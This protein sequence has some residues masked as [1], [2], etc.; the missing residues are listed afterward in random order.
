MPSSV[1]PKQI[2]PMRDCL[3]L[4]RFEQRGAQVG[5]Q[6]DGAI[7]ARIT[8]ASIAS[9]RSGRSYSRRSGGTA[10]LAR[11]GNLSRATLPPSRHRMT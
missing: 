2:A 6:L 3:S 9:C 11:N 4:R 8:G 5:E 1:G 10:R 7:S